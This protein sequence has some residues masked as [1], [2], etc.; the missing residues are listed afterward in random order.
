M[1]SILRWPCLWSES[2]RIHTGQLQLFQPLS[3]TQLVALCE[4]DKGISG[5]ALCLSFGFESERRA[6][7]LGEGKLITYYTILTVGADWSNSI[8]QPG[9]RGVGRVGWVGAKLGGRCFALLAWV[10]PRPA[11]G[12]WE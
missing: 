9:E 1:F 10:L 6:V 12:G 8:A 4:L 7:C 5:S 3:G 11:Y 2:Q